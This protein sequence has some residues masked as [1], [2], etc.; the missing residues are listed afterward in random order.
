MKQ[1]AVFLEKLKALPEGPGNLLDQSCVLVASDV[2]EG[3]SHAI[4]DLPVLVAGRAGGY[5]KHPGVHYRGND[6]LFGVSVSDVLFT[7]LSAVGTGATGVGSGQGYSNK[8]VAPI[9]A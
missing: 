9:V 2:A 5:L 3:L 6:P 1:C 8:V 4:D 7:C